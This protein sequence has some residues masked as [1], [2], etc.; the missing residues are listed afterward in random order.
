MSEDKPVRARTLRHLQGLLAPVA[1]LGVAAGC[2]EDKPRRP[3]DDEDLADDRRARPSGTA[4]T[5]A[6]VPPTRDPGYMVV[7]ML[8]EPAACVKALT[9]STSASATFVDGPTPLILVRLTP[10]PPG[11]TKESLNGL[12]VGGAQG[13]V[14]SS[15]T[16]Q[17][18]EL[19]VTPTDAAQSLSFSLASRCQDGSG[20]LGVNV[21]WSKLGRAPNQPLAVALTAF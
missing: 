2:H 9:K 12:Y 10:P 17:A 20:Q 1:A 15:L 6:R 13:A 11:L 21:D 5:T 7:D 8:P 14:E 16:P 19:R 3:S 4:Y 18:L